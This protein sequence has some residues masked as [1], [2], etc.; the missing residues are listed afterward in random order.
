VTKERTLS[1]SEEFSQRIAMVMQL[2]AQGYSVPETARLIGCAESTVRRDI[3]RAERRVP[4]ENT[5]QWRQVQMLQLERLYAA[6][7]AVLIANHV[8]VSN[9]VMVQQVVR[10]DEGKI[11]WDPVLAPDGTQKLDLDGQ[12]QFEARKEP[13]A[14]HGAVLET[15]AEMRK[16]QAEMTKLL[17][18][19]AVVKQAVEVQHV[20]YT[21]NGTDMSKV[22]GLNRG[23]E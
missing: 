13:L 6:C 9:G 5:K 12:P 18:T 1:P 23:Q 21:I 16:L 19:Q 20:D 22:L 2:Q 4:A 7:E 17:G 14:D 10:D 15:I 3:K 8:V 11:V